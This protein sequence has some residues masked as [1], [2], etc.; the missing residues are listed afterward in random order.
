MS[1]N[2]LHHKILLFFFTIS[3]LL[4]SLPTQAQEACMII[5]ASLPD[6]I[7]NSVL[8]IEGKVTKQYSYWD[9]QHQ[10]IYTS[11]QIQ[12]FKT[13]KGELPQG[14]TAIEVITEGGTIGTTT[15]HFSS[16]LT[17]T[18]NQ[19]GIL[20]LEAS[21][22]PNPTVTTSPIFS[23]YSSMQGFIRYNLPLDEAQEPFQFYS[24]ISNQ[25]YLMLRQHPSINIKVISPNPELEAAVTRTSGLANPAARTQATPVF[26][27]FSPDS[28]S[29]GTN[30]VLTISGSN[31]G[32]TRGNGFVEFRNANDG[33]ATFIKPLASDYISWS[34]NTIKVRVPSTTADGGG[35]A[36][37]G[38][39]RVTNNQLQSNTSSNMLI[40][41]FAVS[42]VTKD[43]VAYPAHLIDKDNLGGYTF[44]FANFPEAA[45]QAFTR[46]LQNWTCYTT[47]N[48]R[49][50]EQVQAPAST[51]SDNIN[52]VRF[53]AGSSL[54]A[55]VLGRTI[56][57]Y[58]GCELK[59]RNDYF[60]RELDF[61]FNI[62]IAWNFSQGNPIS[63]Q[64][65]FETVTLHELGHAHQLGHLIQPGAVMHYA[66]ANN[67]VNRML[68]ARSDI[69]GGNYVVSRSFQPNFCAVLPMQPLISTDCT[70]PPA[71]LSFS[72]SRQPDGPTQLSWTSRNEQNINYYAIERS[73]DAIRWFRIGQVKATG[74]NNTYSSTD[75]INL[76]GLTYY[77][78]RIV[79]T[80]QQFSYSPIRQVGTEAAVATVRIFPNPLLNEQLHFEYQAPTS[81]DVTLRIF[82]SVGKVHAQAI[83]RVNKGE[84]PFYLN[85][86]GLGKGFYVLQYTQG[87]NSN[88]V[89][90]IKL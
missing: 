5:P 74:N 75:P 72:V 1:I 55:N 31:F 68:N 87:N 57:R 15:H 63:G 34:D 85:V 64:Y 30:A 71:L 23:V 33:G 59:G 82:D 18:R 52:T 40:I 26:N 54:P 14:K 25:L 22:L 77:R 42:N 69:N 48:W 51:A 13:L 70:L 37:T 73:S 10:N 6:R 43:D 83:R 2:Y 76:P 7:A 3:L 65:D 61:E 45:R 27:S 53:V 89:K 41:N 39:I 88:A 17:F 80:N 35:V 86:A 4:K 79:F 60:A 16:T 56:S 28:I 19:Q 50:N 11:N 44:Q 20:F 84:N 78:L 29:A 9:S 66:I 90:F 8:I 58:E 36:G 12:V 46:S 38:Q 49:T 32:A 47:V 67:R 81:G 21:K 62:N 24:S